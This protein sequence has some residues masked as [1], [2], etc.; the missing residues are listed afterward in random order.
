MAS[1][2]HFE[3][4]SLKIDDMSYKNITYTTHH[5]LCTGCGVCEDA[6]PKKV[7]SFVIDKGNFRP[8]VN[9]DI[10]NSCGRCLNACPGVGF[11]FKKYHE[12]KLAEDATLHYDK[13]VGA[14]QKC[15]TGYSN[16]YDIRWHSASGGMVSQFLI[17][18]LENDKIDGAVV[19]RFDRENKLLVKC[20][21][22]R[23]REEVLAGRSSKYAPVTMAGMALA[24]KEAEG[25]RF[26]V[27]GIPCHIEGFRKLMTID[28]RLR[29][30]IAGLFSI[31]CSSGRSFYLTEHVF[32]VR[33][34]NWKK[35]T[36]FQYRDEG[37]LGSMVATEENKTHK[38][39]FQ[40]YYHPLRSFFVPRRCLFCIDHYGEVG[41]IC[42][43]DIHIPPF[44]D[45]KVGLNSIVVKDS[46]WLSLLEECGKSG[47]VT[48]TEIPF[49]TVSDSQ[50]MSFK[51]KGRNGAFVN[52]NKK[53]G[54]RVPQYD[55]DYLRQPTKHDILDWY[56]NRFQQFLGSHKSLWWL[57]NK[58]QSKVRIH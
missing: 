1:W 9:E 42:F 11:N 23:T 13:M 6:C 49:G 46:Q 34:I 16:E 45:D 22:A 12:E 14:Y 21:I 27:V 19:T 55:V 40:S 26:V 30:K 7:I 18:L 58:L 54:K 20:Y 38:E 33:G 37:C 17:W 52:W 53:L 43:G 32:K 3:N 10:C 35:L 50:K 48:L 44:S 31:Y 8:V 5:D 28:K 2:M 36:Y 51:K 39:L 4:V 41:D 47:A 15:F 25:N 29:E 24:I 56:Q 57:V